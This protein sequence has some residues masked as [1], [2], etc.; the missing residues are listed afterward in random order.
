MFKTIGS[1][2]G[3][4]VVSLTR[5]P[6][7]TTQEYMSSSEWIVNNCIVMLKYV[8]VAYGLSDDTVSTVAII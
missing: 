8:T 6:P 5:R 1:Q 4:E 2:I 7:F 3:S